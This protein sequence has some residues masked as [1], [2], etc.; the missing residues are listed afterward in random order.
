M[1][2]ARRVG[3]D[4][5]R[6]VPHLRLVVPAACAVWWFVGKIRGRP[7]ELPTEEEEDDG[8]PIE[9]LPPSAASGRGPCLS[10]Q[11]AAPLP[12]RLVELTLP[13][14]LGVVWADLFA[15][16]SSLLADFHEGL[17][18]LDIKLTPW[19]LKDGQR[20]RVLRYL[21]PLKQAFGP[22]QAYNTEVLDLVSLGPR[23][24]VLETRC[25]TRGVPFASNFANYIQWVALAESPAATRL[26]ITGECRFH[27]PVWGPL[28]GQIA[29]ESKKGTSKAYATLNEMLLSKYGGTAA[30]APWCGGG[31]EEDPI[32]RA[33]PHSRS[34]SVCG[35]T[36]VPHICTCLRA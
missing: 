35:I 30:V 26:R 29:R 8:T 14:P 16:G 32:P 22:K 6:V 10:E 2:V 21:A 15:A 13:V 11:L 31:G 17:G 18:D 9:V 4:L 12:N 7:A 25:D 34:R 3:A 33:H 36:S 24:A 27:Q 28:R 20:R 23:L 1:D 5:Q 19:L